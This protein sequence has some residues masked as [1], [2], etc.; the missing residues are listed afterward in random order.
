MY[1]VCTKFRKGIDPMKRFLS[2]LLALILLC[3]LL[4]VSAATVETEE[5]EGKTYSSETVVNPR[6]ERYIKGGNLEAPVI[7]EKEND[8]KAATTLKTSAEFGKAIRKAMKARK[9]SFT[10]KYQ[11]KSKIN[12]NS[13][14][15]K[16]F[17]NT[18]LAHTGIGT[19]GDYLAWQW[20]EYRYSWNYI[21]SGSYYIYTFKVN[22]RYNDTAAEE[23]QV[24]SVVNSI[25]ASCSSGTTYGKALKA[26][27]WLCDNI[28]YDY[29]RLSESESYTSSPKP[30]R[31][32][33]IW[34]AYGAAV[35]KK[36]VCQGYALLLYRV[37]LNLKID[38]RLVTSYDH[39]FNLVNIGT[40][41][42]WA[43]ATWDAG[44]SPDGYNY[45]L[46][47]DSF[48][49]NNHHQPEKSWSKYRVSHYDCASSVP[50]RL[51][52]TAIS[53][54]A[55]KVST[56]RE[57]TQLKITFTDP[58]Y[59]GTS[60]TWASSDK[61]VASVNANGLVTA[62]GKGTCTIGASFIRNGKVYEVCCKVTVKMNDTRVSKIT[63]S[64]KTLTL[65]RGTS[66]TITLKFS[67]ASVY[68]TKVTWSSSN[69][70]IATVSNTGKIT[71]RKKGT[72]TITVT[73]D[74]GGKTATIKVTVK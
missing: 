46:T 37:L 12:A 74:K 57:K 23:S 60:V 33:H 55:K 29:D 35:E 1:T 25:V 49:T 42:Y 19:E 64:R 27:R 11:T 52:V 68:N 28:T 65:K 9:D 66:E 13:F 72:C 2:I 53:A 34:S 63:P 59:A 17:E 39:A 36:C 16:A 21:R 18:A 40:S 26:Y 5:T 56:E 15:S 44:N 38:N 58:A 30:L 70:K 69:K 22:M 61:S 48:L 7:S 71:A 20:S 50:M 51:N 3:S 54:Y 4:P 24:T 8:L 31:I 10:L 41:Y 32:R 6:L 14:Y 45:F 43:D 62:I 67:P 73:A 47:G